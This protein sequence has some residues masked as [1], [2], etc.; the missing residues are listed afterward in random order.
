MIVYGTCMTC[1][2]LL[3]VHVYEHFHS[4]TILVW[5]SITSMIRLMTLPDILSSALA[6]EAMEIKSIGVQETHRIG[7]T[8][9]ELTD[10]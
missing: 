5:T 4:L 9:G 1:I 3:V 7:K 8:A 10:H 2:Q 6:S